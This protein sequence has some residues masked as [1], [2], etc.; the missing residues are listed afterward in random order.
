VTDNTRCMSSFSDF[1]HWWCCRLQVDEL[2]E[3]SLD[4]LEAELEKVRP[5]DFIY[6]LRSVFSQLA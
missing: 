1:S 3:G 5:F 6:K 2:A 4:E